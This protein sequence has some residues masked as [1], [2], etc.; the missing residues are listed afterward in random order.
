[1]KTI[2][3]KLIPTQKYS[4]RGCYFVEEYYS[5]CLYSLED[6]RH[7]KGVTEFPRCGGRNNVNDVA[8]IYVGD[9]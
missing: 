2:T 8:L 3:L 4:C 6:K 7:I 9:K 5:D 1:M